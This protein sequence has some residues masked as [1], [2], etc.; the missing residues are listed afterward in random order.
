MVS[1][2]RGGVGGL[3]A[4]YYVYLIMYEDRHIYFKQAS[5]GVKPPRVSV[6]VCVC[7]FVCVFVC[8]RACVCVR[9]CVPAAPHAST[10][11]PTIG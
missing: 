11:D 8:V 9:V 1:N 7:V 3:G 5:R 10:R 2:L 4:S 6:C